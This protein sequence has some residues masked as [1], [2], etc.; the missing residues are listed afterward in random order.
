MRIRIW[1]R[2][3]CESILFTWA[4]YETGLFLDLEFEIQLKRKI[5]ASSCNTK[6]K[7]NWSLQWEG[8]DVYWSTSSILISSLSLFRSPC[9]LKWFGSWVTLYA[10]SFETTS[11]SVRVRV[12]VIF[13]KW[14]YSS[15]EK[16]QHAS[17]C[18]IIGRILLIPFRAFRRKTDYA[19]W[20]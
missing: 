16:G 8:K 4:L 11:D 17:N 18:R 2:Q 9:Y 6:W 14:R 7:L 19:S 3:Q 10:Q 1:H 13:L 5:S 15:A 12:N 20:W